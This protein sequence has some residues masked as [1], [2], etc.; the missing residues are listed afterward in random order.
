MRHMS[1]NSKSAHWNGFLAQKKE[2]T[3]IKWLCSFD[4]WNYFVE[5]NFLQDFVHEDAG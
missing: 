3:C 1:R 5:Q 4:G 2:E